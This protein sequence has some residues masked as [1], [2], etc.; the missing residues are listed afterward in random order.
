MYS[1]ANDAQGSERAEASFL[2]LVCML[3]S[4]LHINWDLRFAASDLKNWQPGN[5]ADLVAQSD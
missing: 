3:D 1:N 4:V 5:E 2:S